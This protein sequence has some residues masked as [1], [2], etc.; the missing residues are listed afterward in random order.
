MNSDQSVHLL[1]IRYSIRRTSAR[2]SMRRSVQDLLSGRYLLS[3]WPNLAHISPTEWLFGKEWK[4]I[5]NY[6]FR[7]KLKVM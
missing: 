4:V 5:L 6:D 2:L 1:P 7:F 3:H